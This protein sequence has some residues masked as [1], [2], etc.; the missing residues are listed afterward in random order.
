MKRSR[1]DLTITIPHSHPLNPVEAK[2]RIRVLL[3]RHAESEANVNRAINTTS[4]DHAIALSAEGTLQARA[5]GTRLEA[6]F[7]ASP[8]CGAAHRRLLVSPYKRTQQTASLMRETVGEDFFGGGMVVR[9]V[10]AEQQFGLFE[11]LTLAQIAEQF[12]KENAYFVK[13]VNGNGRFWAK[14]PMGESRFDVSLRVNTLINEIIRDE[15]LLGICDVV[16]VSHGVTLR[17]FAMEWLGQTA[18]WMDADPNP[19]NASVR[20]LENGQDKGYLRD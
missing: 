13:A 17:A 14:P 4:S 1:D 3:V 7:G 18:E 12:P 10:L 16:V 5:L 2:L 6:F 15:Q 9:N 20:V 19:E 8:G 11:G